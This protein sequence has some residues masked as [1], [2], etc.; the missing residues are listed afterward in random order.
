MPAPFQFYD[1]DLNYGC[2]NT[3]GFFNNVVQYGNVLYVALCGYNG[4]YYALKYDGV[5][6]S[7]PVLIANV[8][9]PWDGHKVAAIVRSNDGYL[10]VFYGAHDS[11]RIH[12]AVSNAP[13]D[14][15]AWTNVDSRIG[16]L[17]GTYPLPFMDPYS[18]ALYLFYRPL[19]NYY[20]CYRKSTDNGVT[21][22]T[23]QQ[24]WSGTGK[25]IYMVDRCQY[26]REVTPDHWRLCLTYDH[27]QS[28]NRRNLYYIE[29]DF[30]DN[31]FYN[32]SGTDLGTTITGT[33]DE[34]DCKVF[35]SAALA[36][37]NGS[38]LR[39]P[40][41]VLA[42][43]PYEYSTGLYRFG[44]L[45]WNGS[46][47]TNMRTFGTPPR[48]QWEVVALIMCGTRILGLTYENEADILVWEYDWT[49]KTWTNLPDILTMAAA[50]HGG[51]NY[52]WN[53][54]V[55][56][57]DNPMIIASEAGPCMST[58]GAS[59]VMIVVDAHGELKFLTD[60]T[61]LGLP[62]TIRNYS[63]GYRLF[64]TDADSL[65]L[66]L[67]GIGVQSG[68]IC[69]TPGTNTIVSW[70]AGKVQLGHGHLLS[71]AAGSVDLTSLQDANYPRKVILYVDA[72]DFLVK[73]VAG[74]AASAVPISS[75]GRLA[76]EPVPPDFSGSSVLTAND[77]TLCEVWL[78]PTGNNI[79]IIDV[80]DRRIGTYGTASGTA[81]IP[82]GASTVTVTHPL[83]VI[84]S[85]IYIEGSDTETK[86]SW[87]TDKTATTFVIN[88]PAVVT[89]NRLVEWR[90]WP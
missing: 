84:P 67:Q 82:N 89:A 69:S 62:T 64:D 55:Q 36:C 74:A 25:M 46:T 86:T 53:L 23:V 90:A 61:D 22:G 11:A 85:L 1:T 8:D 31:H 45:E 87:I 48:A 44:S 34:T 17:Y 59:Q 13:D 7:A 43:F 30:T 83:G 73:A 49:A 6:W 12:Y 15:S 39:T 76:T 77:I 26:L 57:T 50:P 10:H 24:W 79:S 47:W 78:R 19:D 81:L 35:D 37:F 75:I 29:F 16:T 2:K 60:H 54:H 40:F 72:V 33:S 65:L 42:A 68:C 56:P 71:I 5:H 88:L 3:P 80:T 9:T 51:T 41:G 58:T 21:W 20:Y 52:W 14:I 32:I 38:T 18:K 66:A 70:T 28:P 63:D 4:N 27:Y